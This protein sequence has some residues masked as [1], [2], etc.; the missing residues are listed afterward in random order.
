MRQDPGG[1]A[2]PEPFLMRPGVWV[3]SGVRGSAG[4]IEIRRDLLTFD[5]VGGRFSTLHGNMVQ[6]MAPDAKQ[7]LALHAYNTTQCLITG[8]RVLSTRARGRS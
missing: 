1:V 4:L 3:R 7:H 2:L 5:G 6:P 8:L